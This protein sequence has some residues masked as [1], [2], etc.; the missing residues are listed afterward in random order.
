MRSL[1]L[2]VGGVD[3]VAMI[4]E[5]DGEDM[6][7]VRPICEALGLSWSRQM[8]K[9]EENSRLKCCLM[10]TVAEDGKNRSMLCIPIKKVAAWLF[11][12][13]PNK[14]KEAY[15]AV[16]IAF[17]DEL[18]HVLYS[19]VKGDL[20]PEKFDMLLRIIEEMRADNAALKADNAEMMRRIENLEHGTDAVVTHY[21]SAGS[22]GL[23][24][25]KARKRHLSIAVN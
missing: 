2:C 16:V 10:A 4:A 21:A 8:R 23:H 6:V 24:A 17:Q 5:R 15:K 25:A 20:T 14:V 3:L 7:A 13:N 19:Y 22:Y 9:L 18:Q 1:N 12:I 11:S